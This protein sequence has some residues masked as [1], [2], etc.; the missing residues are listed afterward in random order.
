MCGIFGIVNL[1]K[2]PV[3]LERCKRALATL[4]HRGPD[5][6]GYYH[7]DYVFLGHT[8]LSIIDL[9]GGAQPI[10]TE[11]GRHLVI[12][13]GEIYN[14]EDL[15]PALLASGHRFPTRSDTEVLVHLFE[16]ERERFLS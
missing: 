3:D 13:N 12:F 5:G 6:S 8:R 15:R 16:D 9:D 4:D 10:Y 11:D 14:H 2:R 7:Q 1:D